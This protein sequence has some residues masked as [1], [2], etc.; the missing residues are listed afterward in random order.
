MGGREGKGGG[1]FSNQKHR[2]WEGGMNIF[3]TV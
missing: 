3:K 1:G 2:L